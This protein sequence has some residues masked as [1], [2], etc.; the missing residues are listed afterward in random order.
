[1]KKETILHVTVVVICLFIGFLIGKH[2][3]PVSQQAE[4]YAAHQ[5][6]AINNILSK[7][8]QLLKEDKLAEAELYF[9]NGLHQYP[10]N[11]P[12]LAQYFKSI[13]AHAQKIQ[14]EGDY[15][16]ALELLSDLD[17]FV[18][19]QALYVSIKN[20]EDFPRL[21]QEIAQQKQAMQD[22]RAGAL[23]QEAQKLQENPPSTD[24]ADA[25]LESLQNAVFSLKTVDVESLTNAE[26]HAAIPQSIA[27]LEQIMK[28]FEE[29][30]ALRE[31]ESNAELLA[32]RADEFIEKAKHAPAKS[33]M[34]LYYLN[35]AESIISQLVLLSSEM[36]ADES[37]ASGLV[38]KL[39]AAKEQIGEKEAEAVWEKIERFEEWEKLEPLVKKEEP[40]KENSNESALKKLV[41]LR[42]SILTLSANL[43]SPKHIELTRDLIERIDYS[44]ADIREK[45]LEAYDLWALS[46]MS[47]LYTNY[48]DELG[49]LGDKN[50]IYQ[51]MIAYLGYID[52]RYLS[53]P[54]Q[55]AYSEVFGKFYAALDD[56]QKIKLSSEIALKRKK[57]LSDF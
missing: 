56:K 15:D 51:A 19:S 39:E 40:P 37:L 2:Q 32:K 41:D 36:N 47:S 30:N 29:Q 22:A 26:Y 28:T 50:T 10:G 21:F 57:Q 24:D 49:V 17:T 55:T 42:E 54:V 13:V 14:A 52:S 12:L 6:D 44:L 9:V 23:L 5:Q 4:T 31:N 1:M 45:Q 3:R 35:S 20:I 7:T 27:R 33:E 53:M 48:A 38:A 25:Y 8:K 43:S 16:A 34:T 11:W 18:R 46:Q